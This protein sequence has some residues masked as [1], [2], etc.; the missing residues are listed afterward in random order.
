M[1]SVASV[2]PSRLMR[3]R[4]AD[5]GQVPNLM[6]S[7]ASTKAPCAPGVCVGR[8]LTNCRRLGPNVK[9][10]P[11][12]R[13]TFS[14]GL[15]AS[16]VSVRLFRKFASHCS[17]LGAHLPARVVSTVSGASP[18]H[19][20]RSAPSCIT[21]SL[22]TAVGRAQR[23]VVSP[24]ICRPRTRSASACHCFSCPLR[25]ICAV[26]SSY[27]GLSFVN[28]QPDA[29][30]FAAPLPPLRRTERKWKHP[31]AGRCTVAQLDCER[32]FKPAVCLQRI[33]PVQCC[34]PAEPRLQSEFHGRCFAIHNA[35]SRRMRVPVV[36]PFPRFRR[37]HR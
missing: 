26:G 12:A 5:D 1:P 34:L 31:F 35:V 22:L 28:G 10:S 25:C 18:D 3:A 33:R 7:T 9:A 21:N 32:S 8:R 2:L 4:T 13:S 14:C 30:Y 20:R 29:P 11:V 6:A 15:L 19:S 17:C 36:L 37:P 23:S 16:P 27:V 24:V